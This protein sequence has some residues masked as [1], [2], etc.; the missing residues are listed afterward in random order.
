MYKKYIM[1]AGLLVLLVWHKFPAYS[2]SYVSANSTEVALT[3]TLYLKNNT[4]W[5]MKVFANVKDEWD[6]VTPTQWEVA[7]HGA[8]RIDTIGKLYDIR[9][10]PD[11]PDDASTPAWLKQSHSLPVASQSTKDLIVAIAK[12]PYANRWVTDN[13]YVTAAKIEFGGETG[14]HVHIMS[15]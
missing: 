4:D 15:P 8:E 1:F 3:G 7:A 13:L 14:Y 10:K 6:I 12:D 9:Y 2:K 11:V 5:D